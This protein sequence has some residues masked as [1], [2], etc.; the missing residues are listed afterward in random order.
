MEEACTCTVCYEIAPAE[1]WSCNEGHVL[2]H[3]C[4]N[5]WTRGCPQCRTSVGLRNRPL[6]AIRDAI[7]RICACGYAGGNTDYLVHMTSCRLRPIE[8]PC[9]SSCKRM[10]PDALEQH[11]REV[12]QDIAMVVQTTPT[13]HGHEMIIDAVLDPTVAGGP[14]FTILPVRPNKQ[15]LGVCLVVDAYLSPDSS[16]ANGVR[17]W[18]FGKRHPWTLTIEDTSRVYKISAKEAADGNEEIVCATNMKG[19]RAQLVFR[20]HESLGT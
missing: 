13:E 7:P 10:S 18:A 17:V 11:L 1:I 2:C 15:P 4:K 3:V 19:E 9:S 12:H 5:Q 16:T 14:Q 20:T 8:C 6:E